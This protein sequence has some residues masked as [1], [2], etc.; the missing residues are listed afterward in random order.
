MLPSRETACPFVLI[1]ERAET[2]IN[3]SGELISVALI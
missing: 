2:Q 3:S 1:E